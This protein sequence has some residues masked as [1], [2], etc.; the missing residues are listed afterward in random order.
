MITALTYGYLAAVDLGGR[1]EN[2]IIV[3][4]RART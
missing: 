3:P 2:P 4:S 1:A